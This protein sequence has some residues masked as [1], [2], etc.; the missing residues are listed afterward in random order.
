MV[1]MIHLFFFFQLNKV[2]VS[3]LNSK[4]FNVQSREI[5]MQ[6]NLLVALLFTTIAP[7]RRSNWLN[8]RV[9]KN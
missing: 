9:K 3:R 2:L 7:M 8:I 1:E 6:N 5:E 4:S